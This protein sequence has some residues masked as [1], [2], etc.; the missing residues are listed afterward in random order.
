VRTLHCAPGLVEAFDD[1]AVLPPMV[2]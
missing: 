2:V 1:W